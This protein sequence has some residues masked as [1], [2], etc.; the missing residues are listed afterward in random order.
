MRIKLRFWLSGI[1]SATWTLG[2]IILSVAKP[3]T[4][5]AAAIVR[6]TGAD[7]AQTAGFPDGPNASRPT[8]AVRLACSASPSMTSSATPSAIWRLSCPKSRPAT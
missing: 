5:A 4:S 2:G 7:R 6:K 1:V 3:Q 8:L